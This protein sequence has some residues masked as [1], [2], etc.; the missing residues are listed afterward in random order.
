MSVVRYVCIGNPITYSPHESIG[1]KQILNNDEERKCIFCGKTEKDTTF[2]KEAHLFP[3]GLGNRTFFNKNEC[4]MCNEHIFSPCEDDLCNLL[5]LDRI[6]TGSRKRSSYPKIKNRDGVMQRKGKENNLIIE[7]GG[8]RGKFDLIEHHEKNKIEIKVKKPMPYN[9]VNICKAIAHIGWSFLSESTRESFSYLGKWL[10]GELS[11]FPL[12]L[13]IAFVPALYEKGVFEIKESTS[14]FNKF[15]LLFRF[16]FGSK[17][18]TFY[19]PINHEVS[20]EPLPDWNYIDNMERDEEF[21]ISRRIVQYDKR[22]Y[23]DDVSYTFK[24]N[25]RDKAFPLLEE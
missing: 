7:F 4:D 22:T 16:L 20:T 13:D 9:E 10:I 1:N 18:L 24:Y 15:P 23:P 11:I 6:L 17:V 2:K 5:E 12:H 25:N 3:A 19:I 14:S 21:K 8:D